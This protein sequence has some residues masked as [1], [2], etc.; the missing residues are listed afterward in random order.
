[1]NDR[2]HV[3]ERLPASASR[4]EIVGVDVI[5][6]AKR[7]EV[8]PLLRNVQA[9][10]DEDVVDPSPVQCPKD[11]AADKAGAPRDDYSVRG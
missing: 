7:H 10:D 9:V 3:A 8:L 11:G 6:E 2:P 4:V 5:G 1:M